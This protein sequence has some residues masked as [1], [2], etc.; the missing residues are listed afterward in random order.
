MNKKYLIIGD[1]LSQLAGGRPRV[2]L[3]LGC[4]TGL[5]TRIWYGYADEVIGVDPN[6]DMR[7]QAEETSRKV[8]SPRP[9]LSSLFLEKNIEKNI[10]FLVTA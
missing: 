6:E 5:S 2:V 8:N 10:F 9:L 3:D 7:K 1:I 4:G